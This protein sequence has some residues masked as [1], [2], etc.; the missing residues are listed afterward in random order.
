MRGFL[1]DALDHGNVPFP[2]TPALSLGEREPRI[3]SFDKSGRSGRLAARAKIL[4]LPEGLSLPTSLA[5]W[6]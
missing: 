4:P 6:L 2:L 5:K 3:P 1:G